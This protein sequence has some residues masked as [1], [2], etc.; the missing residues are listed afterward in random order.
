MNEQPR[1]DE[2]ANG[3]PQPATAVFIDR[4]ANA[5]PE[6]PTIDTAGLAGWTAPQT[7]SGQVASWPRIPGYE[8]LSELGSGGMGVVYHA[9]QASLK[10]PVALKMIRAERFAHDEL[11]RFLAEAEAVAAVKDAHV[12]QVYEYGSCEGRPFLA[13]EYLSGGTLADRLRAEKRLAPKA[14]AVLVAKLARAVHAVHDRDIV[15]RDLKPANVLFDE[16]GE[17]K[18]TDFGLAKRG[19]RPDLTGTQAVMGTPAYMAPEQARGQTRFAGPAADIYALGVIL[20][21][22]LTGDRPFESDDTLTLLRKVAEENPVSLRKKVAGIPVDLELICLKC[23]A[24]EPGERYATAADLAADLDR[25]VAGEPVGVRAAGIV[26]RAAKWARRKPTLA[27]AY[28]LFLLTLT[29]T[30]LTGG[31]VWLWRQAEA[32]RQDSI[33]AHDRLAFE[34]GLTEQALDAAE[35]AHRELTLEK[36]QTEQALDATE[37][38]RRAATKARNELDAALRRERNAKQAVTAVNER[39]GQVLYSHS[40]FLAYAEWRNNEIAHM[41]QLLNGCSVKYRNWEWDYLYGLTRGDL[42]TCPGHTR[43][44]TSVAVSPDGTRLASA[45]DDGTLIVW[46][47]S[48][49]KML[50]VLRDPTRDARIV[51]DGSTAKKPPLLK[52]HT[53]D[54]TCLAFCSD[55][56]SVVSGG[57]DGK[58]IAWDAHTGEH[59]LTFQRDARK[60]IPQKPSRGRSTGQTGPIHRDSAS[61][62]VFAWAASPVPVESA[63][64]SPPKSTAVPRTPSGPVEK[65]SRPR[66]GEVTSLACSASGD[67][68]AGAYADGA[69]Q[70][71]NAQTGKRLLAFEAR[72]A[73]VSRIALNADGS[74]L[75]VAGANTLV[76]VWDTTT[77]KS[78]ASLAGHGDRVTCVVFGP[79]GRLLASGSEDETVRL[80]DVSAQRERFVL[81]GHGGAVTSLAVSQDGK[82]LVSGGMD[83][84]LRVWDLASGNEVRMLRGHAEAVS[85]VAFLPDGKR[86]V[87]ASRDRSL[88]LWELQARQEALL[89]RGHTAEAN[90]IAISPDGRRLASASE[91][92]TAILWD[93]RTGAAERTLRGH[94]AAV[95]S[96]SFGPDSRSVATGSEDSTVR[97]W[98]APSGVEKHVLKGHTC[99][100]QGVAFSPV[101]T[102]LASASADG[103]VKLWNTSTGALERTLS[104][105]GDTVYAVAFSPDGRRLASASRDKLII[106]WDAQS[107]ERQRDLQEHTGSVSAVAFSPDGRRLASAALDYVVRIWDLDGGG[108]RLGLMGHTAAV[109]GVAF[110]PD[111]QRL[112]TASADRTV[113]LWDARTGDEVLSLRQQSKQINGVAFSADGHCLAAASSDRTVAV[114][115]AMPS[116]RNRPVE[117]KLKKLPKP[118]QVEGNSLPAPNPARQPFGR[119]SKASGRVQP[120][121]PMEIER[122][123]QQ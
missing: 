13:L 59:R 104:G 35:S 18:V 43:P 26:E 62:F 103:T 33:D 54:T 39:L 79:D 46:D 100:I 77:G 98:D 50:L 95:N 11:T 106:I 113:K 123:R 97:I 120:A 65:E 10:R 80:W 6:I 87:S 110:S 8:I 69:I 30:G 58:I 16:A 85:D 109:L 40:V 112:A 75:A 68:L 111:G 45:S 42:K 15:H 101:G 83:R 92:K 36:R 52:S 71:W 14:A 55:S 61:T 84:V 17:P 5:A 107:G 49:A 47:G 72:T 102:R 119:G 74:R 37:S 116:W 21:E 12:V 99:A 105:H 121:A 66:A 31:A 2:R 48:T 22:C 73:P 115:R 24:K 81:R 53:C 114:W 90:S 67:I 3:S 19:A 51:W 91:D 82:H 108:E 57:K 78:V 117:E 70:I 25:F 29:M 56:R 23:L 76:Q 32:A 4:G 34:K 44:I 20:Y 88:K 63:K 60:P 86:L 118:K 27:T 9:R 28:V 41:E 96:V 38:A 122:R 89:L 64:A 94:D 7:T 1:G 93:A